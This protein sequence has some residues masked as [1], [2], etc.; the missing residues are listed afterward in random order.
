MVCPRCVSAVERILVKSGI[1]A[2]H[3]EL[4]TVHLQRPI[5]E[6]KLAQFNL[7][8]KEVGF[9]LINDRESEIVNSIK[10]WLI[11]DINNLPIKNGK[12]SDK[13][14]ENIRHEYTFLSKLFS[15]V[16]G[17]TIEQFYKIQKVEKVKELISYDQ[18]TMAEISY[19]LNYSSPSHLST[20]FKSVVGITPGQF[21]SSTTAKRKSLDSL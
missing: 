12:L 20:Q 13:I 15:E 16:E 2:I 8:L 18:M 6:K 14:T 5:L 19:Q 11:K 17:K 1:E 7:E 4:G 10:S 21:K 9:T 3:V